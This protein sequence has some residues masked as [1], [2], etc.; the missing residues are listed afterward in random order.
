[1]GY[2]RAD[3]GDDYHELPDAFHEALDSVL[4]TVEVNRW[5][6]PVVEDVRED[7]T[8]VLVKVQRGSG[9]TVNLRAA[10]RLH[11]EVLHHASTLA[12]GKVLEVRE[13]GYLLVMVRAR[14]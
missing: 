3:P 2:Y 12:E 6:N 14:F 10:R 7:G 4:A 1:M 11:D 13:N 8:E 9:E 5:G